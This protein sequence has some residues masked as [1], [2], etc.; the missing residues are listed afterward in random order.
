MRGHSSWQAEAE[1]LYLDMKLC[2][3]RRDLVGLS[4]QYYF[5]INVQF[6]DLAVHS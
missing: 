4:L 1:T 6:Y 3:R 5:Q 2:M